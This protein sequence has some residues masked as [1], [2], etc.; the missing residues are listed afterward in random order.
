MSDNR[1]NESEQKLLG[2]TNANQLVQ[3]FESTPLPMTRRIALLARIDEKAA[4]AY[5]AKLE[6]DE[7]VVH[8]GIS[9]WRAIERAKKLED[10]VAADRAAIDRDRKIAETEAEVE[11]E[12]RRVEGVQKLERL[13]KEHTLQMAELDAQIA[14]LQHR[15]QPGKRPSVVDVFKRRLGTIQ[16]GAEADQARA[17]AQE[18]KKAIDEDPLIDDKEH[19]KAQVDEELMQ[20][21]DELRRRRR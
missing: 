12:I 10:I 16:G 6:A 2:I 11:S 18:T 17:A 19:A 20:F 8:A 3:R 1:W 15:S 13:K 21:L 7:A 9:L 14:G 5:A 4:R